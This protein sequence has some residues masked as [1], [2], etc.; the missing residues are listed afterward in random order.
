MQIC[1]SNNFEL[2][3][4]KYSEKIREIVANT[5][6]RIAPDGHL[7]RQMSCLSQKIIIIKVYIK[8]LQNKILKS[9]KRVLLKRLLRGGKD[10][11]EIPVFTIGTE[12]STVGFFG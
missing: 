1:F 8:L 3:G 6:R 10:I 5:L 11:L 2:N 7:P 12:F 4:S 9:W